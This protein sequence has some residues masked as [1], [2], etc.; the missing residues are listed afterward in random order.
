M[1]VFSTLCIARREHG[2]VVNFNMKS[3]Q[4]RFSQHSNAEHAGTIISWNNI[5]CIL[6]ISVFYY[7]TMWQGF[8]PLSPKRNLHTT[9]AIVEIMKNLIFVI[10]WWS[11]G[12]W[13]ELFIY[14]FRWPFP[15]SSTKSIHFLKGSS[16]KL[17]SI[18][19]LMKINKFV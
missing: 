3:F 11:V 17:N 13:D 4:Q 2:L 10:S 7:Y 14:V 5:I 8:C 6:T 19:I 12:T 15:I 18:L 9:F 1:Y 16:K